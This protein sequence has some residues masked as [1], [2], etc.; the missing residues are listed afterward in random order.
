[1]APNAKIILV[2]AASN[3][4]ADMLA[5][6]AKAN[7]L[8]QAAGGGQVSMSWGSGEFT[9]EASAD[10]YFSATNVVHFASSGDNVYPSWPAA[11]A[12]VVAVGG[13]T[14]ARDAK[15][16]AFLGEDSW[17]SAGAG[18]S[19]QIAR[20]SFQPS[21]VGAMR[22]LPDIS[23][24]ANP[25]TGVWVRYTYAGTSS[26][27]W[28]VFGGTS[29]AAPVMAAIVNNSAHFYA[30]GTAQNTKVYANKAARSTAF[31]ASRTGDC[32]YHHAYVVSSAWNPCTGVGSPNGRL[33][34]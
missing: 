24:V 21:S 15:T 22:G 17:T 25:D 3:S 30:S 2:E 8:V 5:A 6:V 4:F 27:Q 23:A 7:A 16:L 29:V 9:G 19:T 18:F 12:K 13:T 31:R 28:M 20:P 34:Q 14:V 32:G 26:G 33:Y 10:G 1:L 11:S